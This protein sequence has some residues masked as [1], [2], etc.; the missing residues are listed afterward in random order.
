[1]LTLEDFEKSLCTLLIWRGKSVFTVRW[2]RCETAV[3]FNR[4]E[5]LFDSPIESIFQHHDI[6]VQLVRRID[7]SSVAHCDQ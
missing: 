4:L 5:L 3:C 2:I 6:N 7:A 1:M